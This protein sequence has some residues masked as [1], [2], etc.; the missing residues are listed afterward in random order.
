MYHSRSEDDELVKCEMAELARM[1]DERAPYENLW[2]DVDDRVNPFAA[3]GFNAIGPGA[4]RGAS[5]FD[6]TTAESLERFGAAMV[7]ISVPKRL[8]YIQVKFADKDLA[9]LPSVRRWCADAGPRLYAIRYAPHTGFGNMAYQ[10]FCQAGSYGNAPIWHGE[11]KG[12]GL[13]YQSLHLSECYFDVDFAGRV[14]TAR[15]LFKKTARQCQQMFGKDA[16]TPKMAEALGNDKGHVEFEILHVVRPSEELDRDAMDWRSMP[17]ASI[18]IATA[19]KLILKRAGFHSMPISVAR[20]MTSPGEKYAHSPAIRMMPTI[21]G[22]NVMQQTILRAG[23]KAV[24]PALAFFSDDGITSLSTKPNGLNPGLVDESGRLLVARMPGGDGNI[25][26]G[27]EMVEQER[28]VIRR[29][30]MGDYWKLLT[31]ESVQRS[32][33]A[34][35]EIAAK[36]GALIGPYGERFDTD[37]AN[38]VTQ[39]DL[40]L[41]LRAGQIDPFPPE[42]IE[43]GAWPMIEYDN[44]L[45]R[46]ARAEEPAGL[47]RMIEVMTP[48][49]AGDPQLIGDVINIEEAAPEIG[50]VLGVNAK[51]IRTAD[52]I[53]E[54]RKGRSEAEAAQQGV[55]QLATAAGAYVDIAKGNQLAEAA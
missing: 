28:A 16:L 49:A 43:A 50:E 46:M 29:G 45:S 39:R 51:W 19:E 32:A 30:F 25:P 2:R 53:A 21:M 15:R 33:T 12:T 24:D 35:L 8:Q 37:V 3:G 26:M 52:E 41:A 20:D 18:Y 7:S 4:R 40:E 23:H 10:T 34:V 31:E 17:V 9:K 48:F 55:D 47:T 6:A 36:Q 5:N 11:R 42:V 38:P 13:F 1:Q 22:V 54:R 27:M 44:P 14:D